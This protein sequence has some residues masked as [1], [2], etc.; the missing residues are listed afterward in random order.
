MPMIGRV[1]VAMKFLFKTDTCH[2]HQILLSLISGYKQLVTIRQKGGEK[3]ERKK[4][5]RD[6]CKFFFLFLQNP[7]YISTIRSNSIQFWTFDLK[8][9]NMA[10]HTRLKPK[11]ISALKTIGPSILLCH[12]YQALSI[13]RHTI[14]KIS[15]SG[16]SDQLADQ[17]NHSRR[18]SSFAIQR[19]TT[20]S[21]TGV[22]C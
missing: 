3:R 5:E 14:S 7:K 13:M 18:I 4:K 9:Y 10:Y 20:F 1:V 21:C 17:A 11:F 22:P 12:V 16:P 8:G 15:S 2:L 6:L 19:F